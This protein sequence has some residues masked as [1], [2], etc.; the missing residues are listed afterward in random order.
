MSNCVKEINPEKNN[1]PFRD[2]KKALKIIRKYN[3]VCKILVGNNG[4]SGTGF[5]CEIKIDGNLKKLLFTNNHILDEDNLKKNTKIRI[6]IEDIQKEI[7]I[8]DNRFKCTDPKM[9][10]TCIEIMNED[11]LNNGFFEI[12]NEID[13]KDPNELFKIE[14][15]VI[16]QYVQGECKW[17]EGSISKIENN[18]LYH[19]IPTDKGSSG[20]PIIA[21]SRATSVIGIH[22]EG[23]EKE[24]L[25]KGIFFKYILEDIK[26]KMKNDE[27]SSSSFIGVDLGTTISCVG[28]M[29]DDNKIE[30]LEDR[31]DGSRFIPS[32]VCFINEAVYVGNSAINIEGYS[33]SK[34]YE[35][36]RL[37]GHKLNDKI[38]EEDIKRRNMKIIK[39]ESGYL[40]NR[41]KKN[42]E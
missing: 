36:K 35:S 25:N 29:N 23:M 5:F 41:F 32:V 15:Y 17:S 30:I 2:V 7:E 39:D 21:L 37:I 34:I 8:T 18:I 6:I 24:S 1:N 9:D 20:S 3:A 22:C 16:I 11:N 31:G 42:N 13:C 33:K 27:E 14:E 19:N 4:G 28:I 38:I 12:D 10:Y 40:Q 26:K